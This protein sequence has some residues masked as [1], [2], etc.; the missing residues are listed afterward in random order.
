MLRLVQLGHLVTRYGKF[1]ARGREKGSSRKA[2]G[3]GGMADDGGGPVSLRTRGQPVRRLGLEERNFVALRQV[4]G[5]NKVRGGEEFGVWDWAGVGR[6]W[7][8][9]GLGVL[10]EN[11]GNGSRWKGDLLLR[12]D[13]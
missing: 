3:G 7:K 1:G 10:A 11:M 13:V 9:F 8:G 4:Q 12:D 2:A 5:V 6:L